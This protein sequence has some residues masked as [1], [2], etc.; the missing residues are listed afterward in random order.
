[1]RKGC[2]FDVFA[3]VSNRGRS[4]RKCRLV[5]GS[6]SVSY[7]GVTGGDCGFKD[8][9]NVELPPGGERSV[10]LRLN[11]SKYGTELTEDNLVRLAALVLDYSSAEVLMTV[12]TIVLTDPDISVRILG[13]PKQ[14]RRL[15]AEISLK[16][17]LPEPL[18]H[19]SFSIEGAN[20]TGGSVISQ[21]LEHCVEPGQEAKTKIYFT[22]T[23]PGLRKLLVD[24]HSDRLAHVKGFRNVIIGK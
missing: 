11:Y 15:A 22:P 17:P 12:R 23:R 7:T 14:G 6:C 9:L 3:L 13:E 24:F 2:D 20:L 10:P 21:S 19:C 1:M 18:H 8:L 4:E 16:N 5:F